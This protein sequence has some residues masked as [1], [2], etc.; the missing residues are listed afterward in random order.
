MRKIAIYIVLTLVIYSCGSNDRGE[1]VGSKSGSRWFIENPYG[2]VLIPGGSF[3]FGSA[4]EDP[5][6]GISTSPRTIT[7]KKFYMDETEITNSEYALFVDWVRDSIIRTELANFAEEMSYMLD[8]GEE[9][10]DGIFKYNYADVDTASATV[11]EKYMYDNYGGI[12]NMNNSEREGNLDW[13]EPL[14]WD[15]NEYPDVSYAEVM[16]SM[17]LPLDGTFEGHRILDVT[18]F[19]YSHSWYDKDKSSKSV[20]AKRTDFIV[21]ES[22]LVYPDTTVWAKDFSYSYN[23][24]IHDEY[25]WHKAY[26]EYPVVGVNWYQARAFC[27]WRTKMKNDYLSSR[28]NPV[29]V[30]VFRLPT[31]AE[32]EFA[33]RGGLD[34]GTFPWG[35]PYTTSD[36]GCFL[37]NFKPVR[38]NYAVDGALYTVEAYAY[39]PNGYGLYNMSGNVSEW[40]NTA[41][42]AASYRAGSSINT[43]IDDLENKRKVIRGG[44]WKDI[45]HF[46]KV[47]TRDYEYADSLKSYIGFRTVQD[48]LGENN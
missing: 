15:K 19:N 3:T 26:S 7:L 33:A 41:F 12:S 8:E 46:L 27:H 48:Y 28:K 1:L 44:S 10:T 39:N 2:T 9:Q 21:N 42:N 29:R 24:P 16:D 11:Y 43:N 36:R 37:A 38:G 31:E 32:W 4:D 20:N 13:S 45:A 5:F 25:F 34:Y 40:T 14:V 6:G 22:V 35:G 17:Y 47:S 30:P 18:K 23:D